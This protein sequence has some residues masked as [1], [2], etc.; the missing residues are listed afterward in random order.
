MVEEVAGAAPERF[1]EFLGLK[2]ADVAGRAKYDGRSM[3]RWPGSS[4]AML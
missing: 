4:G 2:V 3:C 1:V